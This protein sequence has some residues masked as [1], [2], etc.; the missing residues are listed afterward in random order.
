MINDLK[1][2]QNM[3]TKWTLEEGERESNRWCQGHKSWTGK[4]T[5]PAIIKA[6]CLAISQLPF[7]KIN[8]INI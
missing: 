7:K 8:I 6:S 4:T 3:Q 1:N 2:T 5:L